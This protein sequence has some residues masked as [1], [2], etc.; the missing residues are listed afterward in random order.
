MYALCI[1]LFFMQSNRDLR[2]IETRSRESDGRHMGKSRTALR[3]GSN[4]LRNGAFARG[5]LVEEG[6]DAIWKEEGAAVP[7]G[8]AWHGMGWRV[9]IKNTE[10]MH[11]KSTFILREEREALQNINGHFSK[12]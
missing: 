6:R 12:I 5:S 11:E 9:L 8:M 10:I 2:D 1:H 7:A 4:V 3:S